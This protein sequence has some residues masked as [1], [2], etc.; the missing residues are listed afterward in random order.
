MTVEGAIVLGTIALGQI[1]RT[2]E[3]GFGLAVAG[4]V[5][6]VTGLLVYLIIALFALHSR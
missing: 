4:I 2:R 3:Q 1:K 5:I 6:G